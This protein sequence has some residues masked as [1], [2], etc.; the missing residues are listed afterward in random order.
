MKHYRL[1]DLP[2]IAVSH[3]LDIK[4]RIFAK[5][6]SCVEKISHAVLLPGDTARPHAHEDGYEI[7][8]CA[9]GEAV[10]GINAEDVRLRGGDCLIVEPGDLHEIKLVSKKTGLFYFFVKAPE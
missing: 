6:I 5:D 8:Y 3:A 4:K 10:F 7:F 1:E 2:E 9:G